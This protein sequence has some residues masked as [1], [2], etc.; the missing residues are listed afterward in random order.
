MSS[1]RRVGLV[2]QRQQLEA[3]W[4]KRRPGLRLLRVVDAVE[5]LKRRERPWPARDHGVDG[6][7]GGHDGAAVMAAAAA[8]AGRVA[9]AEA[10]AAATVAAASAAST[11]ETAAVAAPVV[12]V[13]GVVAMRLAPAA[14]YRP[15]ALVLVRAT[16]THAEPAEQHEQ[17][18]AVLLREQRVQVRVGARVERVKEHQQYL[19]LGHVDQRVAGQRG[20]AEERDRG[21]AREVREHQQRHALGHRH[22]GT[23]HGRHRLAAAPDRHVHL[24]IARAYHHECH[25]VEHEQRE[26]VQLVRERRVIH[27]QADAANNR[28]TAM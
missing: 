19:R 15:R 16:A 13:P 26:Q 10:A 17:V 11:A 6:C 9:A 22:V 3:L 18:A 1:V 27:G 5:L 28:V 14:R 2:L 7:N 4:R 8:L 24:R 21:P 25:A 12:V 23:G 20:Q